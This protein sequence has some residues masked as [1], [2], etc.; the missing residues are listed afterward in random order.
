[1]LVR[2]GWHLGL[3]FSYLPGE[4]FAKDDLTEV[5]V[6]CGKFRGIHMEILF[7]VLHAFLLGEALCFGG[8][9]HGAH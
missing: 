6:F 7:P 1:M 4:F 2:Q 8:I 9:G 3:E 5:D